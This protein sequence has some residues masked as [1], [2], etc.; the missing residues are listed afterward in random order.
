MA[1]QLITQE[2]VAKLLGISSEEVNNLREKREI[3]GV[4]DG[5]I[6]MF[7]EDDIKRYREDRDAGG[8]GSGLL[9]IPGEG[10][11]DD[12]VLLSEQALGESEPSTASTI[13]GKPGSVKSGVLQDSDIELAQGGSAIRDS[14]ASDITPGG[15]DSGISL[16]P[17]DGPGSDVKLVA[18]DPGSGL[19]LVDL[20][21]DGG[22]DIP[23]ELDEDS[24]TKAGSELTLDSSGSLGSELTLGS[25]S[26]LSL[27]DDS[28]LSSVV[29]GSTLDLG[30]SEFEDDDL[31]LG[32]QSGIGSDI[33][34]SGISLDSPADSGLSLEGDSL[35]LGTA[36]GFI[37]SD[38]DSNEVATVSNDDEF[39][40]TPTLELDDDGDDAS[41]SQVIALDEEGSFD[42]SAATQLGV[43]D[44]GLLEE[45]F[46][47]GDDLSMQGD[48][49]L[50]GGHTSTA[51]AQVAAPPEAPYSIL[52]VMSLIACTFVLALTGMMMY[53]LIRHMWSWDEPYTMTSSIMD[54][55]LG[56]FEN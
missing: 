49:P 16:V 23:L 37:S 31:V 50:T 45:D 56:L 46:G 24:A 44:G 4:R 40:L 41:G 13:I 35:A 10:D 17:A 33:N 20:D 19:E 53:E 8:S 25:D 29:G 2:D 38:D 14:S 9:E 28:G 26:E 12:D 39:L 54:G 1:Q 27:A 52:N 43:D 51:G 5:S 47:P 3:Y 11:D 15:G 30:G 18:D 22:S 32:G 48:A 7:K 42:D 21:D 36:S 6:W 55:V 34:D